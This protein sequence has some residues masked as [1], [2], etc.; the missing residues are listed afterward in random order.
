MIYLKLNNGKS[1]FITEM[2]RTRGFEFELESGGTPMD[3]LDNL[4]FLSY[5]KTG[6]KEPWFRARLSDL[7]KKTLKELDKEPE[8]DLAEFFYDELSKAYL[9]IDLKDK[10]TNKTKT[11][12]YISEF[13]NAKS[14]YTEKMIQAVIRAYIDSFEYERRK[15]IPNT[16]NLMFKKTNPY[17]TKW[18]KEDC[19][20]WTWVDSNSDKLKKTYAKL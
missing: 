19:P 16:L 14:N 4:G 11:L 6:R 18:S 8:N 12:Y 5:V 7:G 13:L 20:L 10:L 15:Y 1:E 17:S 3:I 9:N 2:L